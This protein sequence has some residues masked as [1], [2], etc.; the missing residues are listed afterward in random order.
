MS[1][2][3]SLLTENVG[4]VVR[5]NSGSMISFNGAKEAWSKW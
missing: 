3:G 4:K 2:I 5:K 1:G